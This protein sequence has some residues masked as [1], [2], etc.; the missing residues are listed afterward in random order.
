MEV[1]NVGAAEHEPT[2]F[3]SALFTQPLVT[4]KKLRKYLA[5]CR[6]GDLLNWCNMGDD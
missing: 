4:W 1:V 5:W 6:W 3:G 2:R